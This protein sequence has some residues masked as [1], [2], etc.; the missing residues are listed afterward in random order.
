MLKEFTQVVK[1]AGTQIYY[2]GRNYASLRIFLES[3][4]VGQAEY[5]KEY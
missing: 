1:Q 5:Q 3:L 4:V 2:V